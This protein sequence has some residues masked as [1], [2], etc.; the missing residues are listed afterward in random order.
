MNYAA[1][2]TRLYEAMNVET[3]AAIVA[4]RLPVRVGQLAFR[5]LPDALQNEVL[6]TLIDPFN[7]ATL[8]DF[9]EDYWDF[10]S[11]QLG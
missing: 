4:N 11:E 6:T 10:L 9:H 2:C 7:W 1:Y 3:R 5:L 8:D